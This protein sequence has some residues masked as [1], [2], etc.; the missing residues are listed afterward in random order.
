[1]SKSV[2]TI[3]SIAVAVSIPYV[4][5]IIS[6]SLG[7]SA[8]VGAT[9]GSAVVGAGLGAANAAVTGGDVSRGALVGGVGGGIGGY[10]YTPTPTTG[11]SYSQNPA[12]YG[13]PATG[14]SAGLAPVYD[15]NAAGQVVPTT[16]PAFAAANPAG[17]SNVPYQNIGDVE[18]QAGG[19]YGD[20][21]TAATPRGNEALNIQAP[22]AASPPRVDAYNTDASLGTAGRAA[23]AAPK[24][25]ADALA[26]VPGEIA[27]KFTDPKA[28]ADMTLRAAGAIAGSAIAGSGM[29]REEKQLLEAQTNELRQLQQTNKALF[30]QKLQQAQ[31]LIGESNYFDPEYFGLQRARRAQLAG[32]TAKRAGLRG[33][34]GA[35]R[36][37]EERRFDLATSRDIGTAFDQGFDTGVAGRSKTIQAGLAA[38]PSYLTGSGSEYQNIYSQLTAADKRRRDTASDFSKLYGSITGIGKAKA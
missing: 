22:N 38:M 13:G 18:A 16:D 4:A 12:D 23:V 25:F 35:Q 34:T 27:K 28:L 6:Q 2:R 29:S 31:D 20:S 24:T 11:Y 15:V 19:Y 26:S 8:V 21:T 17:L 5:P 32:A 9:A 7:L 10:N 36:A 1:M 33:L 3:V 37:S 14:T 30:D